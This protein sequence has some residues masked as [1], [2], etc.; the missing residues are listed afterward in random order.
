MLV[1][2]AARG[3]VVGKGLGDAQQGETRGV[4]G[5]EVVDSR[6]QPL[7]RPGMVVRQVVA[8]VRIVPFARNHP[9]VCFYTQ[10][11]KYS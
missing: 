4:T 10:A 1:E 6:A 5:D 3:F 9:V 8:L 2:A 11:K 7:C